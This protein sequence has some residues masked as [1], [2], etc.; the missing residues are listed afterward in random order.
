[1][2][3]LRRAFLTG[4]ALAAL[5][6]AA[7]AAGCGIEKGSVRILSNDFPALHAVVAAAVK[8]ATDTVKVT[9]KPDQRP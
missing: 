9:K 4:A 7:A 6:A 5:T 1:M 2:T 8:C 3:I